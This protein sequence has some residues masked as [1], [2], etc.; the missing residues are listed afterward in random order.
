MRKNMAAVLV[1]ES[2]SKQFRL[3]RDSVATLQGLLIDWVTG[4]REGRRTLWALRDVSFSVEQGQVLGVIG[5]N[6]AGKSTLLRLLC[7]LGR[8]TSGRIH[9]LG[10]VSGLLELG[11]GV[12]GDLTGRQNIITIGLL[13]GLTKRQ[14]REQQEEIIAFAE[15]EDFIDQPV[16]T[17]SSGMF[18]RL[19]FAVA[20]HFDPD[21]LLLDEVLAV[22]DANFRQKCLGRLA[23]FRK[24]GKTLIITS[25]DTD[26]ILQ[27]CDVVLVLEDGH[28]VMLGEPKSAIK[29]H[30]DLMR[31]RTKKRA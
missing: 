4:R 21:V 30:V 18:V 17:Y 28:V 5:H 26:Q 13:N 10:Q 15:L 2:V 7:N 25:H 20:T 14:I 12:H 11:G 3:Q 9:R 6:G 8:R 16:R 19:A 22:G 31:Q 1:A 27:L 29:C 23:A 24:A